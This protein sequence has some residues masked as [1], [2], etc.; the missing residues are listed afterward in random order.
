M[1]SDDA[2]VA[3]GLPRANKGDEDLRGRGRGKEQKRGGGVV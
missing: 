2:G 1:S 3:Q